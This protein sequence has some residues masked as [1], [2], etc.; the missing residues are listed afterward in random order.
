MQISCQTLV[1]VK[2]FGN[3]DDICSFKIFPSINDQSIFMSPKKTYYNIITKG[4]IDLYE[5]LING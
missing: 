2:C 3:K 4:K 5:I 1:I